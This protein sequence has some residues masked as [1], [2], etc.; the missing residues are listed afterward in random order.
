MSRSGDLDGRIRGLGRGGRVWRRQTNANLEKKW[1]ATEDK[2]KLS[3]EKLRAV[4][5]VLLVVAVCQN[6]PSE[7]QILAKV[8]KTGFSALQNIFRSPVRLA[9]PGLGAYRTPDQPPEVATTWI[10]VRSK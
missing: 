8:P 3:C 4:L 5:G 9:H 1:L 2:G 6:T 10:E 7:I